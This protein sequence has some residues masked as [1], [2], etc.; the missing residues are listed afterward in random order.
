M[1]VHMVI[2]LGLVHADNEAI[3]ILGSTQMLHLGSQ[4]GVFSN[5]VA[6]DKALLVKVELAG[7]PGGETRVNQV[8][9]HF[10]VSVH[11]GNGSVVSWE[12]GVA[13]LIEKPD[14]SIFEAQV[15]STVETQ[16]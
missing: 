6:G 7:G 8:S 14:V 5:K 12:G 15:G 1:L 10:T 9:V 16:G 2:G 11:G 4:A 13:F 3:D